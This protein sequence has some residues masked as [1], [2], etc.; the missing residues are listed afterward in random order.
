[1]PL[2]GDLDGQS[3]AVGI[4]EIEKIGWDFYLNRKKLFIRGTNYYFNLFLS[5]MDRAA[6]DRDLEID[7]AD[8]CEHD[9]AALPFHQSRVLRSGG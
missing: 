9:P 3:H 2:V 7:A 4:R 6:Y 8:E 5:E 1:M